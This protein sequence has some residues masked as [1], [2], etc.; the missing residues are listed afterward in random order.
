M[1]L[2]NRDFNMRGREHFVHNW[3]KNDKNGDWSDDCFSHCSA[4]RTG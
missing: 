1:I 3:N 4:V 2:N